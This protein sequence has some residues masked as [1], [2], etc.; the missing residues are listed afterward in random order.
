MLS[1]RLCCVKMFLSKLLFLICVDVLQDIAQSKPFLPCEEFFSNITPSLILELHID[2]HIILLDVHLCLLFLPCFS[3]KDLKDWATALPEPTTFT[4]CPLFFT[5]QSHD[6]MYHCMALNKPA[7]VDQT[8]V[9]FE[10]DIKWISV[11]EWVCVCG[12]VWQHELKF[13]NRY[14]IEYNAK[15]TK[16]IFF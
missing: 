7:N 14:A 13:L 16:K 6:E 1:F 10:R 9:V 11:C 4:P 12:C 8:F 5:V 3:V 15:L 2:L